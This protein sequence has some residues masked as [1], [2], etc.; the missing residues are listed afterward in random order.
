MRNLFYL[1]CLFLFA[2]AC[3][4][5]DESKITL[6]LG[7][8][9]WPGYAPLFYGQENKF[10]DSQK[11]KIM[12]MGSSSEVIRE[13]KSK[14]IQIAALTID[15]VLRLTSEGIP[16]KVILVLDFSKGADALIAKSSFSK[17]EDLK[18]KRIGVEDSAL[19]GF[20]FQRGLEINGLSERDF[21]VIKFPFDQHEAAF[22]SNKVDAIVTFEPIRTKLLK[23]GGKILFDSS[24]IQGEIVDVLVASDDVYLK[25]PQ[26]ISHL[27]KGW[28]ETL[29]FI[30]S[31]ENQSLGWLSQRVGISSIEYES[32]LEGIHF[33]TK[34]ENSNYIYG[35][36]P[37]LSKAFY[38]IGQYMKSNQ[39][40]SNLVDSK[41]F[42]IGHALY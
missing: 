18:G 9:I 13:F 32:S 23:A 20:F 12:Q 3:S 25:Y 29:T 41:D 6:K 39:M 22:L 31:H 5:R 16:L 27:I 38:R 28:F 34:A 24:Q 19:G 17:F 7:A 1:V 10:I 33:P 26:Q 42:F 35:P 8:N 2:V 4:P 15:E 14:N 37:M 21:K 11:V 30:S 40:I 36:N